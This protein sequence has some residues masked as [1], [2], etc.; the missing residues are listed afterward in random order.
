M[1]IYV[2]V[3]LGLCLFVLHILDLL[4]AVRGKEGENTKMQRLPT[5]LLLSECVSLG[6]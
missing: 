3:S 2:H 5:E 4:N 1:F 6:C